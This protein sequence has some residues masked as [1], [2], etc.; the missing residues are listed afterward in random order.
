MADSSAFGDYRAEYQQ[1]GRQ[2][3]VLRQIRGARGTQPPDQM[4]VLIA[5]LKAVSRDDSRFLVLEH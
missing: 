5:W 3:H 4:P 1:T 2:L